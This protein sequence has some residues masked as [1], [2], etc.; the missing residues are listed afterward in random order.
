MTKWSLKSVSKA[1]IFFDELARMSLIPETS[2][3]LQVLF[4]HLQEKLFLTEVFYQ[5][6]FFFLASM[7]IFKFLHLV[8]VLIFN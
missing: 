5:D 7:H 8:L 4:K 6:L 3:L 2:A 1:Y